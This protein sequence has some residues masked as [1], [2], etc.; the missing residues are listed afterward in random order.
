MMSLTHIA[1]AFAGAAAIPG[2]DDPFCFVL[3]GIGS[4][5]PDI[6]TT[7]SL[8]GKIL[9]PIA[10]FL[11]DRGEHRGVTH[12]YLF[13]VILAVAVFPL[14]S[15]YDWRHWLVLPLG[16]FLSCR[17]DCFTKSGV[18][19]FWP[20]RG[21]CV[22]GLNPNFRLSTGSS[23]EIPIIAVALGI[24]YLMLN[25]NTSGGMSQLFAQN[26]MQNKDTTITLFQKHGTRQTITANIV[27]RHSSGREVKG[28]YT[29]LDTVSGDV[30]VAD[31][32]GTVYRV[33]Y[34]N[35]CQIKPT[36][37]KSEVSAGLTAEARNQQ[38][39][40]ADADLW[41]A[42]LSPTAYIS[43]TLQIDD[44]AELRAAQN[45]ES[46]QTISA[47]AITTFNYAR[48]RD[49]KPVLTGAWINSGDVIIKEVSISGTR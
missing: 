12:S 18:R 34:S 32:S 29:V 21:L 9:F 7:K 2:N 19:L 35:E 31:A 39:I 44:G 33:G 4:L 23:A 3:A 5:I 1:I 36:S 37:I 41:I 16:H 49:I 6:D 40:E 30:I 25:I 24:A 14:W 42:S 47:G 22:A 43:G 48:A 11:E 10:R 28:V 13:T 26:F 45:L 17:A 46:M 8:P 20:H 38:I 15:L 27:G